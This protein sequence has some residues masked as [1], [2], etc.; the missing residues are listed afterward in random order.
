MEDARAVLDQ[1]GPPFHWQ[2]R[3][4]GGAKTSDA[5]GVVLAAMLTQAP[6]GARLYALAADRDQ[7]RLLLDSIRGYVARFPKPSEGL[8]L[9]ERLT[10]GAYRVSAGQDVV[11]EVI[12]ADGPGTWGLRP[13]ML[14]ADE[15]ANWSSTPGPRLVWEAASSAAV[16]LA[17]ARMVVLTS[18]GDP[19]H[20]SRKLLDHAIGSALWRVNETRGPISWQDPARQEELRARLPESSYRRLVLGEWAAAEDRLVDPDDLKACVRLDGPLGPELGRRYVVGLDVGIRHDATVAAVCHLDA[21]GNVVLDR[22]GVWEPTKGRTVELSEVQHWLEE[23]SRIYLGARVVFDPYQAIQL[24]QGLRRAGVAAR[25]FVFS[26][27]SVGRLA[28]GLHQ[29]LRERR[30]SL[31]DDPQLL[32][33]LANVRLRETSPGVVRLDHDSDKHDDRAVALALAV[34]EL[35]T[36]PAGEVRHVGGPSYSEPVIR[37]PGLTL[38]GDRYIDK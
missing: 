6:A 34:S 19:A 36:R 11:L 30:L 9:A 38:V 20:W 8:S 17:D 21:A 25:E 29:L 16:K 1:S 18:P 24:S 33:E 2:S 23:T 26:A 5:A 10:I 37:R 7:S 35:T 12:A 32:D 28:V 22:L 13:W 3:P 4:R 27:T 14:I 31:P 15:L